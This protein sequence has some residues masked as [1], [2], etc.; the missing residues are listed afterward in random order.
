MIRHGIQGVRARPRGRASRTGYIYYISILIKS[1]DV[2][3]GSHAHLGAQD[4]AA[5]PLQDLS[6]LHRALPVPALL[7][8]QPLLR[9][10]LLARAHGHRAP[11]L[12]ARPALAPRPPGPLH[13]HAALRRCL[14]RAAGRGPRGHGARARAWACGAGGRAQRVP[15]GNLPPAALRGR[16]LPPLPPLL[17]DRRRDA[18]AR[19]RGLLRRGGRAGHLLRAHGL[20]LALPAAHAAVPPGA[21]APQALAPPR[22]RL[23]LPGGGRGQRAVRAAPRLPAGCMPCSG[24]PCPA[25]LSSLTRPDRTP[26]PPPPPPT[27]SGSW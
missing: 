13:P 14:A 26:S 4:A 18:A 19:G 23:A 22:Q 5:G 25:L 7:P 9:P 3:A 16:R 21:R 11:A 20:A 1:T 8:A 2:H 12:P 17:L 24:L 27:A 10:L 15:G 6:P